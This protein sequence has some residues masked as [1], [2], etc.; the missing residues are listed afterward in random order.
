[1]I[2][3]DLAS[4]RVQYSDRISP[5]TV[6]AV[7]ID[8]AT[9][10]LSPTNMP[11]ALTASGGCT[12]SEDGSNCSWTMEGQIHVGAGT[13]TTTLGVSDGEYAPSVSTEFIVG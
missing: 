3:V 2:S 9:L 6:T 12:A 1:V 5:V 8:S 4:Q 11:D 10:T 7:D 13:Y